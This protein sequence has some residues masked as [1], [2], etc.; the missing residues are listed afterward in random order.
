MATTPM[1][2]RHRK[3]NRRMLFLVEQYRLAHPEEDD[4]PVDP[5]LVAAWA[6][7]SKIFKPE[8]IDP[9]QILRRRIRAALRD[10]YIEDDQG[11][12]VHANQP[13]MV[14]V[15]TPDGVK[16]RSRWYKTFEMP[17]EKMRA[18]GQLRRRGAYRDVLQIFIDFE[19]YNDNNVF[20]AALDQL[21]FNFNKDIEENQLP[22]SYDE[23]D[24]P[25]LEDE[26]DE[27]ED[28]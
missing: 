9:K 14:E 7:A 28:I 27:D 20:G 13:E 1:S 11:R 2:S 16:W 5:D 26:E 21:D 18:A 15:R 8:P 3:G 12:E 24:K 10:D 22:T 23:P 4:N 25:T 17:P 6:L 19:S